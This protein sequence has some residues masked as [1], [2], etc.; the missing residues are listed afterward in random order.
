MK[1]FLPLLLLLLLL[2]LLVVVDAVVFMVVVI[3]VLWWQFD[4]QRVQSIQ[5]VCL[6]VYTVLVCLNK[7]LTT[8]NGYDDGGDGGG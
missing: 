3:M 7:K 4:G 5:S 6:L 8:G 2:S 1:C